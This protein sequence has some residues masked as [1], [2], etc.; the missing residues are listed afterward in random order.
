MKYNINWI[1]N[2][3]IDV[4]ASSKE[5]AELKIKKELEKII[6]KN[7]LLFDNVGASAIQGSAKIVK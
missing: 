5:E 7:K 3:N 6:E 1:I 4:E 2:G